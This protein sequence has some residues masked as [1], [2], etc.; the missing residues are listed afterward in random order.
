MIPGFTGNRPSFAFLEGGLVET[1]VES[2]MIT[3]VMGWKGD[4]QEYFRLYL[5]NLSITDQEC[6]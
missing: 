5:S 3:I 1:F 4:I 2:E 6:E